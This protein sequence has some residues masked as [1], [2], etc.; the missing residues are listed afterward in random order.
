ALDAV[1]EVRPEPPRLGR[2]LEPAEERQHLLE[3]DAELEPGEVRADAVVRPTEAEGGM[4]V[5]VAP[6]VEPLRLR[7]PVL[8]PG[9]RAVPERDLVARADRDSVQL[10]VPRGR[11]PEVQQRRRPAQDLLHGR[12]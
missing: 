4:A 3:P 9:R 10:D 8:V 2:E 5:R 7:G 1:E 6:D 11:A 12:G